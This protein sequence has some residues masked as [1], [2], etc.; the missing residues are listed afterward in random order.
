MREFPLSRGDSVSE[1]KKLAAL[2][3]AA[4]ATVPG[5]VEAV[6]PN[7]PL[8]NK[9]R[10]LRSSFRSKEDL[11]AMREYPEGNVSFNLYFIRVSASP[12]P[13]FFFFFFQTR[14][15]TTRPP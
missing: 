2:G 4:S 11:M 7:E 10:F 8:S 1:G 15:S 3:D 12:D 6:G 5:V 13:I 9:E 14:I